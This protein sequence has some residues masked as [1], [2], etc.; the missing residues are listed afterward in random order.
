MTS[1]TIKRRKFIIQTLWKSTQFIKQVANLRKT[2]GFVD[3][4]KKSQQKVNKFPKMLILML[5]KFMVADN[6]V[7]KILTIQ[8]IIYK[9]KDKK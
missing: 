3:F 4:K 6:D 9:G 8:Y 1:V 5:K 2:K 7:Y